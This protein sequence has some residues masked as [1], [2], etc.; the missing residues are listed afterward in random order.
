MNYDSYKAICKEKG[1]VNPYKTEDDFNR[2]YG[3]VVNK[4]KLE[5]KPKHKPSLELSKPLPKQ[6]VVKLHKMTRVAKTQKERV[7][8]GVSLKDM[9]P[10][11]KRIHKN[12]IKKASVD[13]RKA[14]G[15]LKEMTPEERA[16]YNEKRK[17]YYRANKEKCLA[18]A[19]RYRAN[20]SEEQRQRI[21]DKQ[22]EWN[23]AHK[24]RRNELAKLSKQRAKQRRLD[25]SNNTTT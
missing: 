17:E 12:K 24:E 2:A 9:T 15:T 4:D 22:I 6:K 10:E 8:K 20:M 21:R 11:E 5:I 23:N 16:I 18:I 14:N 3:I 7:Y 19:I 25:A 1:I 13:R